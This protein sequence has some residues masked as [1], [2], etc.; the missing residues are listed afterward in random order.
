MKESYLAKAFRKTARERFPKREAVL[1]SAFE[2]RLG[3]LRS[4][5]AGASKER[6]RHLESQI[7]PDIASYETLRTVMSKEEALQTV[8]G[9]L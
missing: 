7:L 6:L 9:S 3:E 1:N 2:K 8:H 4:E 5:H